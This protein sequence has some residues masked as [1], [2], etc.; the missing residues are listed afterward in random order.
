[1]DIW[2]C[3]SR[4]FRGSLCGLASSRLGLVAILPLANLTGN[5]ELDYLGEGI[6]DALINN[7]AQVPNLK[8]IS[9]MFH[10]SVHKGR[11]A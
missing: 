2:S 10:A 7:I 5:T 11:D 6:T 8:V 9:G 3:W 4:R 1:M